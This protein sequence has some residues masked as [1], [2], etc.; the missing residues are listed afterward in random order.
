M[1]AKKR[2]RF[3]CRMILLLVFALVSATAVSAAGA[4]PAAVMNSA[5]PRLF[6]HLFCTFTLYYGRQSSPTVV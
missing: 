6:R 3:I 2:R 4:V 1:P 5:A